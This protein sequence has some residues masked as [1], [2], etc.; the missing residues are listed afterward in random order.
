MVLA[1]GVSVSVPQK[2][3]YLYQEGGIL[4][5]DGH[6]RAFD[7][8]ARGTVGGSGVG[9]VVLKRLKDA[10][11][12]GDR[13]HATILGSAINND[14]SLKI[15]YTAPS[16]EGQAKAIAEAQAIAGI[17]PETISYIEAHGTGTALGDPVEIAALTQAFSLR[18][19]KKG[20]CA[21]GSVK[22]NIGHLGA[23]AGVAGL[24]KTVLAL[25]H[26]LIPPSL[27]FKEP[28][29]EIDFVNSPFYVNS[30]LSEWKADRSRLAG[31]SSFGIGGTNAHVILK[32]APTVEV[33]EVSRP[34]QLLVLSA[35]TESALDAATANLTF[36]LKQ[37]PIATSL[38]LLILC[39]WADELLITAESL[40]ARTSAMQ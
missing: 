37:E 35:K 33:S 7:A 28:N 6:C 13:I 18:T 26:K 11:E 22:T 3:G 36:H 8:Q 1:G 27:H 15:G 16:V 2:A 32:E 39:K 10:L 24:I 12:D 25:K 19:N 30:S 29:P 38:I 34:W 4:S 5:P 23:A 14:G 31:V 17:D 20:F 21:I 9:I 40:F